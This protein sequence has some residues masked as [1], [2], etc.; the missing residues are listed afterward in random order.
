M[1]RHEILQQQLK[2]ICSVPYSN[3]MVQYRNIKKE[4]LWN[5]YYTSTQKQSI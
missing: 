3:N 2:P 5:K 1:N 4:E